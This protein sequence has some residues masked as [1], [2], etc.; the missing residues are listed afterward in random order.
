MKKPN[1]ADDQYNNYLNDY[2]LGSIKSNDNKGGLA[3]PFF[4]R[5]QKLQ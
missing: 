5:E 1:Q 4:K 2:Y 3:E